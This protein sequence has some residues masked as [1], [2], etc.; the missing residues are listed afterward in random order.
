MNLATIRGWFL[1]LVRPFLIWASGVHLPFT[2]KLITGVL[3]YQSYPYLKP[4]SIFITVIRGD[5]T[6]AFIPGFWTHAAIYAPQPGEAIDERVCQAE[7]P[8]VLDT[9]LVTFETTKDYML[10]IE[11]KG[12]GALKDT[13]MKEASDIAKLQVGKPYDFNFLY[14]SSGQKAFYCSE[15]V[16]W[17][18]DQ[19][20]QKYKVKSP[21]VPKMS[22]GVPTVTPND[23]ATDSENFQ[24]VW[25]SRTITG[26]SWWQTFKQR[27]STFF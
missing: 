11:P 4:G 16:W 2:H 17:C 9:D 27:L 15:L 3:Y 24:I 7:A 10:I 18:Y 5:L 21:F 12:L 14:N 8:G 20:C 13:I 23:I 26:V 19:V 1:S 22:L 25:D 6:T